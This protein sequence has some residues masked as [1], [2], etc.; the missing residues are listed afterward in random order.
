M[1]GANPTLSEPTIS[2]HGARQGGAW[3]QQSMALQAPPCVQLSG[4]IGLESG[5]VYA[6]MFGSRHRMNYT[7]VGDVVNVAPGRAAPSDA[8]TAGSLMGWLKDSGKK[9]H[10][11]QPRL[12]QWWLREEVF[13]CLYS[14]GG[15][16][17]FAI[18]PSN[19]TFQSPES[20][21][22]PCTLCN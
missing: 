22:T 19:P 7:V 12:R 14:L 20:P 5:R 1:S 2:G 3:G 21:H 15:C 9:G 16:L 13:S 8:P 10:A 4:R 17:L 6:G 18:A 11:S